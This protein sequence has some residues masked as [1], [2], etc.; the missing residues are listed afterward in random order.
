MTRMTTAHGTPD[1]TLDGWKPR[2]LGGFFG[3]V[4]PL[5]ARKEGDTWAYAVLAEARHANP[6]GIVHGGMLTTLVDHAL[7]AI[8][9]EA[10][11]RR[12][13]VTVQLDVQFLSAV[14]PGQLVEARGRIV[15]QTSSLVFMQGNL[16]VAGDEVVTASAVLKIA[17]RGAKAD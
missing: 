1:P 9:W 2:A 7:S 15:R 6:A 13:C 12:A 16:S 17:D 4:G 11:E 5:W 10:N 14:R 8:A 3:L